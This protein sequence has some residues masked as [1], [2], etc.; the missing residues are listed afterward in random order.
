MLFMVVANEISDK[1]TV[2]C[3]YLYYLYCLALKCRN[4]VALNTDELEKKSW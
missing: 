1:P 2:L 4:G 3:L